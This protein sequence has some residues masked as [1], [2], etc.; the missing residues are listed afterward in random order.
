MANTSGIGA[1][2][3]GTT[4]SGIGAGT[5]GTTSSSGSVATD[6]TDELIASNKVEGTAVYNRRRAARDRVQFHGG[7][8][9]RSGCVCSD[10]LW[11][12]LGHGRELSPAALER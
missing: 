10:E 2:M 7:Q 6:E 5:S 4:T 11:R 3:S 9:L 1:G 12:A 8:A